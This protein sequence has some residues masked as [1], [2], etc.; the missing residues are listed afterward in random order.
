ML[1]R[2]E[3]SVGAG[4]RFLGNLDMIRLIQRALRRA[5]IPYAL[6]KGFNPHIKL[7]M[8]TVLPVGLW[9]EREYF[10]IEL[11]QDMQAEDFMQSINDALPLNMSI[12]ECMNI[13]DGEPALMKIINSASYRFCIEKTHIDLERIK[14][15]ILNSKSIIIKSKGKKKGID[16]DLRPGIYKM[17]MHKCQQFDIMEIWSSIGTQLNIRYDEL[18]EALLLYGLSGENIIE[19]YRSGNYIK[20][21]VK[22]F[23]PMKR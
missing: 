19:I 1:L 21:G 14:T 15:E 5:E 12:N 16:K 8:G 17:T 7:S 2:A 3:Y 6:S 22:Y 13:A 9:G 10:D 18:L 23:N 4:L 20:K 11:S